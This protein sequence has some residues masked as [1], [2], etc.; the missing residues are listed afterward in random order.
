MLKALQRIF[1]SAFAILVVLFAVLFSLARIGSFFAPNFV[2]YLNDRFADQGLE[3]ADLNIRWRGINPVVEIG[4]VSSTNLQVEDI[5]A[6]LNL[7]VSFWRNTYVFRTIQIEHVSF[8]MAQS[9]ACAIEF[10]IVAGESLGIGKILR[11]TDNID[12]S[13]SSSITCGLTHFKHEGFFRTLRIDNV[14]R[15]HASIRELGECDS[16]SISLLYEASAR[17]FWRRTEERLLNVQAH[18]FVVPTNLLGWDF[19]Q[20]SY[21]NAQV[22]MN[23]TSVDAS[24]VGNIDFQ[25][26][27]QTER[28]EKLSL[29]L[30][31]TLKDTGNSGK[32]VATL[33]DNEQTAIS[34]VEH[35]VQQDLEAGYTHG[36]SQGV[37]AD[38]VRAFMTI[39]G[40]AG[41]PIHERVVRLAPTGVL[42]TVH[43]LWDQAGVTYGAEVNEFRTHQQAGFPA[44]ALESAKI[45][46]R[47]MLVHVDATAQK[48]H[49]HNERLFSAPLSLSM[50]S[51][52][53]IATWKQHHFGCSIEGQWVPASLA[54]TVDFSIGIGEDFSTRQQWFRLALD[55]PSVSTSQVQP[56]AKSFVSIQPFQWIEQSIQQ[57]HFNDARVEFAQISNKL[58]ESSTISLEALAPFVDAEVTFYQDWPEVVQGSGEIWLTQDELKIEVDSAYSQ[59]NHI[60]QGTIF[61]P[62]SDP[63]LEVDFVVDM[64]Y[65]LLQSYLVESP[66]AELLPF[67][68]LQ[69][70][71]SGAIDLEVALKIPLE[72]GKESL[73][74]V[75]VDMV[76]A[77]VFLDV[78]QANVQLD[79]IFGSLGYQFPHHFTSSQ[80]T[81]KFFE[82]PVSLELNTRKGALDLDEA[83]IS[84]KSNTSVNAISHLTGDW[85]RTVA[86]GSSHVHGDI[87]FPLDGDTRSTIDVHTD[88]VGVALTLP[89]PFHKKAEQNRPMHVQITLDNPL[90]VDVSMDQLRV[91]TFEAEGSP[92][93]GSIG[94]NT[95]PQELSPSTGDWLVAGNLAELVFATDQLSDATLPTNLNVEFVDLHIEKLMR[96]QFQLHDLTLD[97]TFGGASSTLEVLAEEGK[98]TLARD[99][100]QD[101]QLNVER[102][103]L[104]YSA[105]DTPDDEPLDP[106]VFLRLPPLYVNVQ[107]LYMFDK[108]GDAEEYGSWTFTLD[109]NDQNVHLQNIVANF[110]GVSLDTRDTTGIVWD[111]NANETRF[112]GVIKGS[113]LLHVLPAFDVDAEVES[114]NF[115]VNTD[116][117]W[118]G[119]LF[120]INTLKMSG[121]IH[122]DAN[123]GTLLEVEAGQGILRLLNVFNIAPIIQRMDFD[124]TAMFSKGFN[125]DRILFDVTLDNSKVIIQEPI[126]IKGRS[127]EIRFSGNANLADENL[128][129]DVV[130]QLP[131]SNN[132]KWYVALIT[133]NPTAF[134]GT[135][136]GSRIFQSQLD[137]ISSAKY[138]VEGT[139]ESPK[140]ELIGV[141]KDD[142]R[143]EPTDDDTII[144]E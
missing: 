68:P 117:T 14:F 7:L 131:F 71:G 67:D 28:S 129:M 128:N 103:R 56:Y 33:L 26:R 15:M 30:G 89:Q 133:G 94:F 34:T 114:K 51:F 23:G 54:E 50:V 141:F 111:T 57:G 138:K 112:E 90:I 122:G 87:I 105:L 13:F 49:I 19:M 21:I 108:N 88:L 144:E 41:H 36:W 115:T 10:P 121:R 130:V 47:G 125:Y 20:E 82:E 76:L 55:I 91:R 119:S 85:L 53:T 81:G 44:L 93:R 1:V 116:L 4:R 17:G 73:W 95:T 109:T 102:L 118:P 99:E 43:W 59:G 77:D 6:E 2:D 24:L 45:T 29:D 12:V 18:D 35:S 11:F 104:W 52:S 63:L 60:E 58:Q 62:F 64:T 140:V 120:D 61:L 39:F 123:E 32:I 127:S 80:L 110:R 3:F 31:F 27:G 137:R 124:P 66:L 65:L 143:G 46:G 25:P 48:V 38:S 142:L 8:T 126:H 139:F 92:L 106:A 136:I 113:N 42:S 69:F 135:V 83:V 75:R 100:G 79:D 72:D 134:L 98:A 78:R 74:D 86:S 107:E 37:A 22:L 70:D 97:G 101:W 5:T 16:C 96:G 9:S 40:V 132:L 84:F